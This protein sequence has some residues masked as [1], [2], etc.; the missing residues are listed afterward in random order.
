MAVLARKPEQMGRTLSADVE[1]YIRGAIQRGDLKPGERLGSARQLAKQW[2]T[3]YGAVRQSLETLASKGIVVRRPRAGTFVSSDPVCHPSE[4]GSR[5]II[6]LLIPDIRMPDCALITRHLQDA[7]HAAHLEVLVSSTDNERDRYDQSILRH[8]RAGVGGLVLVSPQHARI[9]L[10]T[11]VEI[12][13]SGIPVV[14][15]ARAMD[16]VHWPT[17]SKPFISRV[18]I[19]AAWDAETLPSSAIR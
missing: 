6:G 19:F 10:E 14:N 5:N 12:E 2:K 13:K 9:S 18:S 11:L 1:D 15:Y 4:G 7:G 3:S 16:V 8:L 17:F